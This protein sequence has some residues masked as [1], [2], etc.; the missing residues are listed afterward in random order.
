MVK[1]SS[2]DAYRLQAVL[3]EH[4]QKVPDGSA[5]AKAIDYSRRRWEAL[6]RQLNGG[7]L[8]VDNDWVKNQIRLIA[9]G[10]S[11]WLFAGSLRAG[12]Q[13]AAIPSLLHSA[14]IH[15][16]DPHAYLRDVLERLPLQPAIRIADL[17]PHRWTATP[18]A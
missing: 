11:N 1:M 10:R 14:R 17:L 6:T 9:L 18:R 12:K 16:H 4:R 2:P 5:T 13:A 15:G 7:R 3:D 8:P